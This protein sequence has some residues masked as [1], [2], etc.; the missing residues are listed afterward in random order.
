MTDLMASWLN[1]ERIIL[2]RVEQGA[3]AGIMQPDQLLGLSGMDVMTGMLEGRFPIAP[4]AK[5]LKFCG[6]EAADGTAVFQ[7]E[8]VYDFL[9]PMNS[10]HGGWMA[11]ILDSAM[12]SA[13]LTALPPNKAYRTMWLLPV[14]KQR[15]LLKPSLSRVRAIATALPVNPETG[16][17]DRSLLD[18]KAKTM[19]AEAKLVDVEGNVYAT[20]TCEC[21]IFN[22]A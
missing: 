17:F 18:P 14:F 15:L 21:R 2:E 22:V 6:I 10:I 13:V 12:G 7:A 4:I 1:E 19:K 16:V 9:N 3:G 11:T 5:L 20:A 8:P